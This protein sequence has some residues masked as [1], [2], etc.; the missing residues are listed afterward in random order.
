[1]SAKYLIIPEFALNDIKL[2]CKLPADKLERLAAVLA[3]KGSVMSDKRIFQLVAERM[4]IGYE[5]ALGLLSAVKNLRRQRER[6]NLSP[7]DVLEDLKLVL[8]ESDLPAEAE[9]KALLRLFEKTEEDHFVEKIGSLKQALLPHLVEA[10]T[11]VDLRPVFSANR[12]N[13]DGLLLIAYLE[14]STHDHATDEYRHL[15]VQL[16]RSDIVD[17]I[18]KLNDA[19]EKLKRLERTFTDYDIYE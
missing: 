10:S 5:E 17:L 7:A 4:D 6:N 3:D 2:L 13:I 19:Q 18:S 12:E 8:D 9:S 1:M 15:Q 14:L 11:I 16:T